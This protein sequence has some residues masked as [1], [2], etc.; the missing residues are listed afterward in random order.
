MKIS[1]LSVLYLFV[2]L[3]SCSKT[4]ESFDNTIEWQI[5]HEK[6]E[7]ITLFHNEESDVLK[8]SIES[9]SLCGNN[10][11]QMIIQQ[12]NSII[13]DKKIT[14]FPF[15]TLLPIQPNA[16][17]KIISSVFVIPNSA[18]ECVWLGIANCKVQY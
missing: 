8:L 14:S 10:G 4:K 1:V 18:I 16:E 2:L 3:F 17:I 9:N 5:G 6:A 12:N 15:D 13:Y 11:I 7:E